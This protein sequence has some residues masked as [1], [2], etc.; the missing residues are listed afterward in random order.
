MYHV[1]YA[2][3]TF[4]VSFRSPEF[5]I[6]SLVLYSLYHVTYAEMYVMPLICIMP[7]LYHLNVPRVLRVHF[8]LVSTV[9]Y[10]K[11]APFC[12]KSHQNIVF[13]YFVMRASTTSRLLPKSYI[14]DKTF[15]C[16]VCRQGFSIHIILLSFFYDTF[17]TF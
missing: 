10:I 11:T 14:F 13:C 3:C 16:W 1:T 6:L 7:C 4:S 12:I 5:C 2:V 17:S 9:Q 15:R 8:L